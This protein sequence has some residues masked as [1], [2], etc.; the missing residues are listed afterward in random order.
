MIGG[1]LPG[2]K[3]GIHMGDFTLPGAPES[4]G[5]VLSSTAKAAEEASVLR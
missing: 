5:E 4:L 2:M 3:L 1:T